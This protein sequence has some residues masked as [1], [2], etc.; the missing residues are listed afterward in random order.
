EARAR[1]NKLAYY[2][3]L[4]GLPNRTLMRQ[5]IEQTLT[6]DPDRKRQLAF[7]CLD[8]DRFKDINDTFG[9]PVGDAVLE[10]ISQRL[11]TLVSSSDMVSRLSG[12]AFV[13]ILDDCDGEAAA[14]AT[15]KL[16]G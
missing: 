2:D 6:S 7:I 16:I 15:Q 13:V 12:D 9:Q 8:I 11:L 10:A 5:Q 14:S 1:I 4:T 3:S